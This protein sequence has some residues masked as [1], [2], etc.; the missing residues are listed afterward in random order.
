MHDIDRTWNEFG[1]GE[2]EMGETGF[3]FGQ[4][5]GQSGETSSPFS[6]MQEMELAAELL[7][8]NNESELN[9]FL[10]SLIRKAG[11]AVGSFIS[12][13]A[14][15]ALGG[16]LKQAAKKAL[17]VVGSAIG[18][19]FGG[20]TGA[21]IGGKL[22]S[23]AGKALG[24]ELEGMSQEDREFEV[25]RHFV[26]FG[27]ATVKKVLQTSAFSPQAVNRAAVAAAQQYLPGL[28]GGATP[29]HS[30]GRGGRWYRRGNKVIL[31]GL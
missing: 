20:S 17:P 8:V 15:Q 22:A 30:C 4:E 26:R 5:I 18:G 7:S 2:M 13:P 3:E 28:I 1:S 14:G 12:S 29:A 24:L 25:A 31:V 9:N 11:S 23:S 6:E 16:I 19:Y 10:G 21:N 27:G